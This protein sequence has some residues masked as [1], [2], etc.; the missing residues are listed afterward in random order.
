MW[1]IDRYGIDKFKQLYVET[2][3]IE[4]PGAFNAHFKKIYERDF[5][6]VDREWRLWVL[7][8]KPKI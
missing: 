1:L 3:G 6:E 2:D 8:Y 5:D 7:R 4:E